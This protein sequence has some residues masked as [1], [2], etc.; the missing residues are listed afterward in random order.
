MAYGVFLSSGAV[1]LEEISFHRYPRPRDLVRLLLV[2]IAENFG[3]R[4][5]TVV[6]RLRAFIDHARGVR[7]WGAMQRVGWAASGAAPALGDNR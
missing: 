2:G 6:W 5:L 4:Q 7:S 1:L 3:Y